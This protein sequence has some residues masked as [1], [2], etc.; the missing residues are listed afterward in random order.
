M[1]RYEVTEIV[2]LCSHCDPYL[3]DSHCNLAY[4]KFAHI[5]TRTNFIA[6]FFF[7]FGAIIWIFIGHPD[8]Y[9]KPGFFVCVFSFFLSFCCFMV[10]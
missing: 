8:A 9:N 4:P 10:F 6:S 2:R 5:T 1:T 7:L 3:E